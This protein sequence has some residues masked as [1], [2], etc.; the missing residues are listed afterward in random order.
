M[1]CKISKFRRRQ[2]PA[3]DQQQCNA[4]A[5][6]AD[7]RPPM[8]SLE[9]SYTVS[10]AVGATRTWLLTTRAQGAS[11][12]APATCP[13]AAA[14]SAHTASRAARPSPAAGPEARGGRYDHLDEV[15]EDVA[16]VP[17]LRGGRGL[18]RGPPWLKTTKGC[19]ERE[20][21]RPRAAEAEGGTG[22]TP[23]AR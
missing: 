9:F 8:H 5:Q 20:R 14:N 16:H 22:R 3:R 13:A 18:T 23:K 4:A 11:A 2:A 15:V 17:R 1:Q 7:H 10:R 12:S 21:R 19:R 6:K